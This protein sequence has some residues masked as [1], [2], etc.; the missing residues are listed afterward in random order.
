DEP[1]DPAD[2]PALLLELGL[3][4]AAERSPAAPATLTQAGELTTAPPEHPPA[5]LLSAPLLGIWAH[6]ASAAIICRDAL[7]R[8]G[9]PG[10]AADGLEA[11]L[12]ANAVINTATL[13]ET[14]ARARG[15]L[16]S[17]G[18][19]SAWRVNAALITAAAAQPPGDALDLLAPVLA[20]DLRD[21]PPDSL[22][23]VY[24]LLA[25]I[26]SE[27][28]AT[29]SDI[30]DSVLSAA[31]ERGSMSMVAHASCLHSMIMRRTGRLDD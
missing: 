3:A 27:E 2:R 20:S 8:P 22:S 23:V 12:F 15:R 10:P 19:S 21:V 28:L 24:L 16:A 31:R 11:E 13:G 18:P 25:L 17:P 6:H 7:A 5:A 26:W 4:L 30:C 9:D 29:A 14:L 1:P